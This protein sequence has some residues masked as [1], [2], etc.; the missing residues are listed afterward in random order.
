MSNLAVIILTKN[1][2]SQ[3][4]NDEINYDQK[5]IDK[6]KETGIIQKLESKEENILSNN[7]ILSLSCSLLDLYNI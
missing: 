5:I 4:E 7:K 6:I 2:E 1:E 3:L